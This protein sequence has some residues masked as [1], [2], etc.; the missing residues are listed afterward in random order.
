MG[1]NFNEAL[2]ATG[3]TTATKLAPIMIKLTPD[4]RST[5]SLRAHC[6][7]WQ[8]RVGPDFKFDDANLKP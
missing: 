5:C 1:R 3:S 7:H 6:G 2:Q 4:P 8:L